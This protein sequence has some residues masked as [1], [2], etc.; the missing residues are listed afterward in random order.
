MLPFRAC[1]RRLRARRDRDQLGA[2]TETVAKARRKASGL[3]VAAEKPGEETGG[4]AGVGKGAAV[5]S[6]PE[7]AARK[8]RGLWRNKKGKGAMVAAEPV[9]AA[10]LGAWVAA[11]A[12]CAEEGGAAGVAKGAFVVAES[13]ARQGEWVVVEVS[14]V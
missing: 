3:R 12:S 14:G 6:K 13:V 11:E 5:A 9:V 4:A 1:T 10:Y 7:A 2:D 8:E